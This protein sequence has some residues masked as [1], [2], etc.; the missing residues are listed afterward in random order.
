MQQIRESRY[1]GFHI[2]LQQLELSHAWSQ[3][4]GSEDCSPRCPPLAA[5]RPQSIPPLVSDPAGTDRPGRRCRG[6]D[7]RSGPPHAVRPLDDWEDL[8]PLPGLGTARPPGTTTPTRAACPD[9]PPCNG[10]RSSDWP[11]WNRS[12][13][14]CTSPTGPARTWPVRPSLTGSSRP[15]V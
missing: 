15:S 8:P 7:P 4:F 3:T 2:G 14:A 5:D 11:A 1:A 12:P 13:R 10:P 6:T 9:S